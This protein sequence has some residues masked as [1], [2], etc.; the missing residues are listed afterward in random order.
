LTKIFTV[1]KQLKESELGMANLLKRTLLR[2]RTK[3]KL[4][5]VNEVSFEVGRGEIMGLLGPNG[6]GK[7]TLIKTLCT[8]LWPN[9]G[10]ARINDYDIREDPKQTRGSLGTV[11]DI[12]MGWYGRLSCR[13]NLLFYGQLFGLK[14]EYLSTRINE[15]ID[16]VGLGEKADEWQQ[17]LS[18]GMKRKLD[19]ARALLPDPPVLL[20]DEPTLALD[21]GSARD[22]RRMVRTQLC[23]EMG[24]TV[25]WT[26]HNMDEASKICDRV[27]ILHKGRL[28]AVGKPDAIRETAR[29]TNVVIAEVDQAGD[30]LLHGIE[31][32]PGVA[33]VGS[34]RSKKDPALFTL[35]VEL[36]D[37][38]AV[39]L[40][41]SAILS[42]GV[43]LHS[44]ALEEI[45]LEEAMI[46]MTSNEPEK[47]GGE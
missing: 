20:L 36:S 43:G 46:R 35:R 23:H 17:K 42:A 37:K 40:V 47:E 6:A 8:L 39:T 38:D 30:D 28:L 12:H 25:L 15:V 9:A 31:R 13:Q 26:T 29:R 41:S 22:L 18:S 21:P 4:T 14:G 10:T 7:T 33:S 11:L 5:A 2:R 24:K 34:E 3:E 32:I 27:A 44:L 1:K 19:L 45:S 16:F